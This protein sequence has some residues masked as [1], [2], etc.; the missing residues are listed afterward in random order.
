MEKKL[1]I[2]GVFFSFLFK[3]LIKFLPLKYY[4]P[5]LGSR[6]RN[7]SK[8]SRQESFRIAIRSIR[9][10]S[11]FSFWKSNCF[12]KTIVMKKYLHLLGIHSSVVLSLRKSDYQNLSAHSFLQFENN[13]HFLK[14]NNFESVCVLDN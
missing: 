7:K 14:L 2:Y 13:Y 11:R 4:L 6:Q 8:L 1:F 10:V 5:L 9:R 12:V 3:L